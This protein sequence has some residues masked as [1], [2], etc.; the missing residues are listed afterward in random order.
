[1]K[2]SILLSI[3]FTTIF[4]ANPLTVNAFSAAASTSNRI[5]TFSGTWNYG[6]QI[7]ADSAALKGCEENSINL[8]KEMLI[9]N[10][11]NKKS[12]IKPLK[13]TIFSRSNNTG[14][15]AYACNAETC[16]F[17]TGYAN[18]DDAFNEVDKACK[19]NGDINGCKT[20]IFEDNN[21]LTKVCR[22]T[23]TGFARES[24]QAKPGTALYDQ[25]YCRYE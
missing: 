8:A 16:Y 13:C 21:G 3:I 14:Y 9:G 7:D 20:K 17:E 25:K 19:S 2:S 22:D 11:N 6:T 24:W 4:A 1:M 23:G 5:Q 10:K 15:G 12:S 18:R